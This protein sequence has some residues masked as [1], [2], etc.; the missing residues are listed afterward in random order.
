VLRE[1]ACDAC[2]AA[3]AT[4]RAE[5]PR[6][7]RSVPRQQLLSD[8]DPRDFE[9][10]VPLMELR[11]LA[12]GT[13]V[14]EQG[15]E[16]RSFFIVV[17]GAVEVS[18][19][20]PAGEDVLLAHLRA[21]A[22]FGEMALLTDSPR[23]ARVQCSRPTLLIELDRAAL[24]RL[25]GRSG[26]IATVLA[27]YTRERLLR[28]LMATSP[29]FLPLDAD[30]RDQLIDL[31]ETSLF[32]A[33]EVVLGEGE[34]GE[35]LHVVLSGAVQVTRQEGGEVLTL[36]ELGPG[37]IFGEISLFQRRPATATVRAARKTV[38]LRLSRDAFNAHVADF[39]EVVAHVYKV[40][41]ERERTNL[42]LE[43][44]QLVPVEESLVLV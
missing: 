29:L 38:L 17:R 27:N 12:T 7:G 32:G 30:R 34:E 28:N 36:A 20:T 31:F 5:P 40:A 9:A 41:V 39:P 1:L 10:V 2:A 16:G 4:A 25:A 24:E 15:T 35:G 13:V 26:Q 19:R 33:G 18:Q 11:A 3:V 37:Q 14:I 43:R 23:V 22:F 8:L 42:Q 44:S 21:G 6:A